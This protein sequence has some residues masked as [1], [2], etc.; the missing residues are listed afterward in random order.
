MQIFAHRLCSD[1]EIAGLNTP[2]G[3]SI[4]LIV[5]PT[6]T[7]DDVKRKIHVKENIP[8][9][10][11]CLVFMGKQLEATFTLTDYN[12]INESTIFMVIRPLVI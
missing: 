3:R 1:V 10:Q 7:I 5:E 11:Q 4:V 6:E 9:D 8:P 2:C 12:I